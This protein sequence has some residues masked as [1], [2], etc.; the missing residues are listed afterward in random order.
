MLWEL[1]YAILGILYLAPAAG[2]LH[3]PT[4]QLI[5]FST[6]PGLT[7]FVSS[8]RLRFTMT[9]SNT[10]PSHGSFW[11]WGVFATCCDSCGQFSVWPCPLLPS[12]G[13]VRRR[14]ESWEV[15]FCSFLLGVVWGM[16]W[17]SFLWVGLCGFQVGRPCLFF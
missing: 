11:L 7:I 10:L 14:A 8:F 9:P 5:A 2:V 6:A 17:M 12:P 3:L 1:I 4:T 15:G 13:V 16:G